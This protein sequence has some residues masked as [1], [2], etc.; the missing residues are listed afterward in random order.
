MVMIEQIFSAAVMVL[1][2]LALAPVVFSRATDPRKWATAALAGALVYGA[3]SYIS[4]FGGANVFELL[5]A[6]KLSA[7]GVMCVSYMFAFAAADNISFGKPGRI[8]FG[9]VTGAYIIIMAT[10][11]LHGMCLTNVTVTENPDPAGTFTAAYDCGTLFY[12]AGVLLAIAVVGGMIFVTAKMNGKMIKAPASLR[13]FA[14]LSVLVLIGVLAGEFI[15]GSVITPICVAIADIILLITVRGID[16]SD[17]TAFGISH[18]I[19]NT[20]D[21]VVILDKNMR[22][23]FANKT[24]KRLFLEFSDPD[25]QKITQFISTLAGKES[26]QRGDRT[27]SFTSTKFT[28]Y[29][30]NCDCTVMMIRDITEQILRDNRLSEEAAIDSITGLNSRSSV[31][32]ILTEECGNTSGILINISFDGFKSLNNLYGHEEANKLLATF[33]SILKNNTNSDDIRGRLGGEFFTV[34]FKNCDSEGVVAHFTMRIEEQITD[35]M[36]KQFGQSVDESVASYVGVSVGGVHVPAAGRDYEKLN[37]IA[38]NELRKIKSS[39][40]HGYSIFDN[41]AEDKDEGSETLTL[42]ESNH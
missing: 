6:L 11:R 12:I 20:S 23:Q 28:D 9:A 38:T 19:D 17:R 22:F 27:Y 31:V 24:A 33:G 3:A 18:S 1:S 32:E 35:A 40:G 41:D 5:T 36:H 15:P 37:E 21:G 10:M 39:G 42:T 7:L 8:L 14:V 4:L 2:L 30:G 29:D 34:F 25:H 26:V 13:M 16:K